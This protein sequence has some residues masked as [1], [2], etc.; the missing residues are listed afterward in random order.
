MLPL[1]GF[2]QEMINDMQ[3]ILI[4]NVTL[5]DRT[6]TT[7]GMQVSIL[8]K[9]K[10]L[11]MVT[12]DR[13]SLNTADIAFD[14]KGGFILGKLEVGNLAE[15]IILDKDPRTNVDVMLNTKKHAVFAMSDGEVILNKMIRIDI[16]SQDQT[17]SW[18]SYSPPAIALPLSY[19]NKRKWN[20]LRTKPIIMVFG[21][22]LLIENTRWLSQDDVNESQVGNLNNFEGGSVRGFRAGLGGTF[23][24]KKPWTYVFTFGTRAFERG[25]DQ[26]GSSE[27][28]LYDYRVDIPVGSATLSIG[29]TRETISI[30]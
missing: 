9:Q 10:K 2:A 12:Q 1:F 5:I 24:F 20:V 23:N 14:A 11:E 18:R 16:D 21:G 25:F 13:I 28:V 8:I 6:G 15:F 30:S 4:R 27:F 3:K 19:Q 17:N 26:S 7:E 29:K 22:A